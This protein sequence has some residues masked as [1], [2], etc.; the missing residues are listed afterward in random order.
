[1]GVF[2]QVLTSEAELRALFREP[3]D[4]A[5]AKQIDRLDDACRSFIAHATITFIGTRNVDGTADVSPKGGPPGFWT[6]LDDRR[7][8]MGELP[9]NNRLDTYRNLVADPAIGLLFLVPSVGETLRVNGHGFVSTDPDLLA[10]ASVNG[11]KPKVVLGVEVAEVFLHCAKA[12]RRSSLWQPEQWPDTSQMVTP[13]CMLNS[14]L[15]LETT[16]EAEAKQAARLD[17][18]Y[19][20]TMWTDG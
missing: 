4:L 8:M 7:L 16:P 17:A 3:S 5:V 9:G 6:V 14:A 15:G 19:A 13:Y 11:S 12:L 2:E 18:A 1:M 20:M 10:K